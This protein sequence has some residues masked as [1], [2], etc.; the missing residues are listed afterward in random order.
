M[1]DSNT[2]FCSIYLRNSRTDAKALGIEI[3]KLSTWRDSCGS[4][5]YYEVWGHGLAWQGS[6]DNANMAKAYYIDELI[7][8]HQRGELPAI[9]KTRVFA[10]FGDSQVKGCTKVAW[11]FREP[12]GK[13]VRVFQTK[14]EAIKH[15][16]SRGIIVT[17]KPDAK[18]DDQQEAA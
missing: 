3:P 12:S 14:A 8:K 2:I 11:G 18:L 15:S 5:P 4:S 10:E 6:A 13:L 16:H 7:E 17:T 1:T 9:V